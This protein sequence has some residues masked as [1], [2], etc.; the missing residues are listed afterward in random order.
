MKEY[1]KAVADFTTAI[2]KNSN[3]GEAYMHRGNTKEMMRNPEGACQDW[4]KAAELG[5]EKAQEY[6]NNQC[7]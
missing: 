3:Y 5:V 4:A 1:D 6:I 2:N 7:K